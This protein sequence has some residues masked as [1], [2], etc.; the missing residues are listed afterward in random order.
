MADRSS[1]T[2]LV[3]VGI[4]P[5]LWK[6]CLRKLNIRPPSDPVPPLLSIHLGELDSHGQQKTQTS[7]FMAALFTMDKKWKQPMCPLTE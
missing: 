2:G 4:G 6:V 1:H 7:M 5:L 3:G